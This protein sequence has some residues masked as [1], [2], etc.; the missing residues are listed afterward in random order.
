MVNDMMKVSGFVAMVTLSAA[1]ASSRSSEPV[2]ALDAQVGEAT[3][4][5]I[6]LPTLAEPATSH[7]DPYELETPQIA[8][9]QDPTPDLPLSDEPSWIIDLE[10]EGVVVMN[11]DETGSTLLHAY[12]PRLWRGRAYDRWWGYDVAQ[13]GWAAVRVSAGSSDD[14]MPRVLIARLP[15]T[16]ILAELPLLTEELFS[17]MYEK[18][19]EGIERQ[20][21]D[22]IYMGIHGEGF[23]D[24]L[25]WSPDG[26]TLA[27]VAATSGISADIFTYDSRT[28]NVTQLTDGPNQPQI[29]GGLPMVDTSCTWRSRILNC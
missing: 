16:K 2:D 4:Y 6:P 27:F 3:A 26:E 5:S 18:D 25:E 19:E 24:S 9:N 29:R 23:L 21:L 7:P 20:F 11:Y 13:N 8:P 1:C 17:K 10:P 28:G 12:N 15:E 14:E 22:D